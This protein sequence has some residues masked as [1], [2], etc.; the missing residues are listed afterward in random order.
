ML[1]RHSSTDVALLDRL[2]VTAEEQTALQPIGSKYDYHHPGMT[3][4]AAVVV[5]MRDKVA[6]VFRVCGVKAEGTNYDLASEPYREFHRRRKKRQKRVRVFNLVQIPTSADGAPVRG[7]EG[8]QRT[9]VQRCDGSFFDEIEVDVPGALPDADELRSALDAKVR[10]AAAESGEERRRRLATAPQF[11]GRTPA[12]TY[13]Y[14]RNPDVIAEVLDRAG[15]T[16]ESCGRDAPFIR[17]SDGTPYLEVHHQT[18][19][20]SGGADTIA[21]AVALCPNCH[22]KAHY[23]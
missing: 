20:A 9:T 11:P 1:L 16:C 6:G 8:R 22:R 10:A 19:L 23:G 7:W 12:F 2:G 14:D 18:P 13:V 5:I 17:R 4:T 3:K 21:N 15:G